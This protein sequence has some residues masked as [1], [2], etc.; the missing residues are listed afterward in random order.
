[1]SLCP[2]FSFFLRVPHPQETIVPIWEQRW[3]QGPEAL[4]LLYSPSHHLDPRGLTR[5]QGKS[6]P[7]FPHKQRGKRHPR[8]C[9]SDT[10]QQWPAWHVLIPGVLKTNLLYNQVSHVAPLQPCPWRPAS[11]CML[12][13]QMWGRPW[14]LQTPS[15]ML[16]LAF[17][18][19]CGTGPRTNG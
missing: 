16:Q 12:P 4:P 5:T 9:P 14:V 1:M 2:S 13:A 7:C 3:P 19:Q 6:P 15:G 10:G 8:R 18:P 11:A 17:Y